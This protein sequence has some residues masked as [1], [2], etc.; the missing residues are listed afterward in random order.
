[1]IPTKTWHEKRIAVD[2]AH[3]E[4]SYLSFR[5]NYHVWSFSLCT[6]SSNEMWKKKSF[7]K[8]TAVKPTSEL[9]NLCLLFRPRNFRSVFLI[10]RFGVAALSSHYQKERWHYFFC[11]TYLKPPCRIEVR[12][13]Q[14]S[15]KS[16][17]KSHEGL[18]KTHVKISYSTDYF[19]WNSHSFV[20]SNSESRIEIRR[21]PLQCRHLYHCHLE[22]RSH[23]Q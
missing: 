16:C 11:P 5:Q 6:E 20:S 1:M 8:N 10:P 21:Q 12:F 13:H 17:Q 3:I 19:R 15:C 2:K 9:Q 14:R 7:K 18:A 22:Q 4:L 23:I